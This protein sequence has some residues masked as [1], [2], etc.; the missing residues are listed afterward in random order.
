MMKITKLNDQNSEIVNISIY[1]PRVYPYAKYNV[2]PGFFGIKKYYASS[3]DS[4]FKTKEDFEK[5]C[6]ENKLVLRNG[7]AYVPC[8]VYISFSYSAEPLGLKFTTIQEALD[9]LKGLEEVTD[10]SGMFYMDEENIIPLREFMHNP[11]P[12]IL[13]FE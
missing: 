10:L 4:N 5:Y 11:K 7:I 13:T 6:Q 12:D 9:Y 3:F 2:R 1:K 8:L